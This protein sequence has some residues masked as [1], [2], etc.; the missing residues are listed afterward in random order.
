MTSQG[1]LSLIFGPNLKIIKP[2]GWESDKEFKETLVTKKE[3]LVKLLK[4]EY[5]CL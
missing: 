1:W 4:S 2:L 3:F 5:I